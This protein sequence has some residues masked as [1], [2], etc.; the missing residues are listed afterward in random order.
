MTRVVEGSWG[1]APRQKT[2]DT[3]NPI[4]QARNRVF[5]DDHCLKNTD[6][7]D[8]TKRSRSCAAFHLRSCTCQYAM[9]LLA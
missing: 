5:Y 1:T 4:S 3:G 9:M 8:V 7:P 6:A 2:T